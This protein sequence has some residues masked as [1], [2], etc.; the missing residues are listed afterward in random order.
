MIGEV[1]ANSDAES[2]RVEGV[3]VPARWAL[4][5]TGATDA[6][7]KAGIGAG[8]AIPDA[9]ARSVQVGISGGGVGIAIGDALPSGAVDEP[10]HGAI[11]LEDTDA[12]VP[13]GIAS[14]AAGL[15]HAG[16]VLPHLSEHLAAELAFLGGVVRVGS[17]GAVHGVAGAVEEVGVQPLA[18]LTLR[19]AGS[20]SELGVNLE[21][22][23]QG[24]LI[25][26][27]ISRGVG[28]GGRGAN[29]DAAEGHIIAISV[30]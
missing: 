9:V 22:V 24:A 18:A 19:H 23:S 4:L 26:A 10:V 6:V 20:T 15:A 7:T 16:G 30:C 1:G 12:P 25:D 8:R 28:D 21:V 5:N 11:A 3:C 29:G 2:K 13:V 14:D 27:E 17:H